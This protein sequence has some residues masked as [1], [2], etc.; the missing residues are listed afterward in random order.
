MIYIRAAPIFNYAVVRRNYLNIAILPSLT[1]ALCVRRVGF[2]T[3]PKDKIY[4]LLGVCREEQTLPREKRH[5]YYAQEP[6]NIPQKPAGPHFEIEYDEKHSITEVYKGVVFHI[7]GKCKHLE[8]LAHCKNPGRENGM[9]LWVPNWRVPRTTN[10][11]VEPGTWGRRYYASGEDCG[12]RL[13]PGRH[14]NEV[15][16]VGFFVDIIT[17][18]ASQN[19]TEGAG[20]AEWQAWA[21]IAAECATNHLGEIDSL[22]HMRKGFYQGKGNLYDA[23]LRTLAVG[24]IDDD[25]ELNSNGLS[26]AVLDDKDL[27]PTWYAASQDPLLHRHFGITE[28]LLMGVFAPGTRLGDAVFIL[29]GGDVPFV[30]RDVED[31]AKVIVG[32]CYIRGFMHGEIRDFRRSG[33]DGKGVQEE[34][35]RLR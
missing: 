19:N 13:E 22:V 32:E 10:P 18:V 33:W 27:D 11:L 30:L 25:Q 24:R 29:A 4:A 8:L 23:F 5:I 26:P 16:T 31:G 14:P 7:V 6:F 15:M 17:E 28:Q 2:A 35:I 34:L 3:N 12:A 21:D 9:P 1:D 20:P